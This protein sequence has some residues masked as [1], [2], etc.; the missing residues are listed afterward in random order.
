MADRPCIRKTGA[1]LTNV[2]VSFEFKNRKAM[3][4]I[5]GIVIATEHEALILEVREIDH[6]YH[7]PLTPIGVCWLNRLTGKQN[8]IEPKRR[9]AN[10]GQMY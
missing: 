1:D 4:I 9:R 6:S 8:I 7:N 2:Q 10:A 5:R 3:P